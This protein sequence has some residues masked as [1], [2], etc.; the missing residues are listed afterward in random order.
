MHIYSYNQP[1][2]SAGTP[3]TACRPQH[4]EAQGD[5]DG[6]PLGRQV[7]LTRGAPHEDVAH[8]PGNLGHWGC[9]D[10]TENMVVFKLNMW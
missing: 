6:R 3:P 8:G 4:R 2:N 10:F 9:L 1:A 5:G 7:R